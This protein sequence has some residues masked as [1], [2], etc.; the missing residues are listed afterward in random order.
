MNFN[1]ELSSLSKENV[2]KLMAVIAKEL[3]KVQHPYYHCSEAHCDT[4]PN[5]EYCE[6]LSN[7]HYKI[8]REYSSR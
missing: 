4:C 2:G 6:Y 1:L 7:L 8:E 3:N 5:A